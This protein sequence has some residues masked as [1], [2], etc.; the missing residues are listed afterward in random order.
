MMNRVREEGARVREAA[1]RLQ[2]LP[3]MLR[4]IWDGLQKSRIQDRLREAV[5]SEVDDLRR[6]ASDRA[7]TA[8]ARRREAETRARSLRQNLTDVGYQLAETRLEIAALRPPE[9]TSAL[10]A[11]SNRW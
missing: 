5:A 9:S 4:S 6:A 11:L 8:D 1:A 2:R 3:G 7:A 10:G